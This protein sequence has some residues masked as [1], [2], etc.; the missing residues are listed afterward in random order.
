MFTEEQGLMNRIDKNDRIKDIKLTDL[1]ACELIQKDEKRPMI[2]TKK[3]SK[4]DIKSLQNHLKR[5]DLPSF[6]DERPGT[7]AIIKP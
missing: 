4:Q 1:E 7:S 2:A 5:N 3:F 6:E